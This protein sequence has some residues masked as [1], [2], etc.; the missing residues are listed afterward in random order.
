MTAPVSSANPKTSL[1]QSNITASPVGR[2]GKEVEMISNSAENTLKEVSTE[3]EIPEEVE[4]VGVKLSGKIELP[5]DLKK[6][7][8]SASPPQTPV[9][10]ASSV[11]LPINDDQVLQGIKSPVT[12][13]FRWLA[14]WS[15]RQ[16]LKAHIALKKI[17]GSVIR[18]KVK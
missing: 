6:I 2:P 5:P 1:Q 12:S 13:A 15:I 16:L 7:G 8:V 18:V 14:L 3:I 11:V 10:S 4:R 9:I 17:H